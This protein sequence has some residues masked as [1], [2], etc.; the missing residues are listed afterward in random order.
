MAGLSD[1]GDW[2]QGAWT[3]W[4]LAWELIFN[5]QAVPERDFGPLA[6]RG[7]LAPWAFLIKGIG[8]QGPGTIEVPFPS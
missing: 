7:A 5:S 1:K 6:L 8:P 3:R 4:K 2:A